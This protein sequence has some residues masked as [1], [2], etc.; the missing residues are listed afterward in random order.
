MK[1]GQPF[2]LI[3][4]LVLI[5]GC[6]GSSG[7]T[8]ETVSISF[9]TGTPTVVAAKIGSGPFIAESLAA[10]KMSLSLPSGT[11]DFAVAYLCTVPSFPA[12][13]RIFEAT[14]AD[15]TSFTLPCALPAEPGTTGALTG[16]INVTAITD[17]NLLDIA[18][19][20]GSQSLASGITPDT[21]FSLI[22]PAGTD[23][24]EVLAYNST[25]QGLQAPTTLVAARNFDN[26]NVP[27]TLNSGS[28][29][30]LGAGDRTTPEQI[31]YSNVPSGYA[32]PSTIVCL[33]RS[34]PPPPDRFLSPSRRH[35]L[36]QDRPRLLFR[37]SIS[38]T[39][40]S[41]QTWA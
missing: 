35:G 38:P 25:S 36:I 12:I 26:Q 3:S 30:V 2:L 22:A 32:A 41:A 9:S 23:R 28:Q 6:G 11:S 5:A 19:S 15:G 18:A 16:N 14:T 37:H 7:G 24:V 4:V 21:N 33:W 39:P 31:T 8:P 40:D 27:G 17:T 29:V 34:R 13:E 20:S 1:T 10:G